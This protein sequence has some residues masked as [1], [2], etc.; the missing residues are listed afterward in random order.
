MAKPGST[1]V[2]QLN[3][4]EGFLEQ[5]DDWAHSP[6]SEQL[7]ASAMQVF[8]HDLSGQQLHSLNVD[9]NA[10]ISDL[11]QALCNT[12]VIPVSAIQRFATDDGAVSLGSATLPLTS[13]GVEDGGILTR[14]KEN[15]HVFAAI[16]REGG[17][18]TVK[19]WNSI[20]FENVR[21]LAHPNARV[22][23]FSLDGS[24]LLTASTAD[25]T[26]KIWNSASDENILTLD[27]PGVHV[28]VFSA[29]GSVV[30][31]ASRDGT[32]KTWNSTSGENI[33]TLPHPRGYSKLYDAVS[34]PDGSLVLTN[35]YHTADGHK[36]LLWNSANG[37]LIF[38]VDDVVGGAVL[39]A[40]SSLV[41]T[42]H[43]SLGMA[44]IRN[45]TRC[46]KFLTLAHLDITLAVFSVD[47][48][49]VLTKGLEDAKVWNATSGENIVTLCDVKHAVFSPD[50]SMVLTTSHETVKSWNSTSGENILTLN[51]PGVSDA[52]FSTDGSL[53]LTVCPSLSPFPQIWNS[54]SGEHILTLAH[55]EG[56]VASSGA[57]SIDDSIVRTDAP[58]GTVRIWNATSGENIC[59]CNGT[60][61]MAGTLA[62]TLL[63][64]KAQALESNCDLSEL[65][66][67]EE[68]LLET[69]SV[70]C[71][72][73]Q[74]DLQNAIL[75]S[76]LKDNL[77]SLTI[78]NDTSSSHASEEASS[79]GGS[80]SGQT[81]V[82][83][84]AGSQP[85]CYVH[86]TL[87]PTM[88]GE[89]KAIQDIK[90]SDVLVSAD[91]SAVE[92]KSNTRHPSMDREMVLLETSSFKI[93]VTLNHRVVVLRGAAPQTI[94][95]GHLR[96]GDPVLSRGGE[97]D[98]IC[99]EHF[100]G[101][102]D[103][104]EM[105]LEPDVAIETF[106]IAKDQ[107]GSLLTKGKRA[108]PRNRGYVRT[109]RACASIEL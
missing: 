5:V 28:A 80:V 52:V 79:L 33:L 101:D 41:L 24:L 91:G 3:V 44:Q 27:H 51:L 50:G 89:H 26:A 20:D 108:I 37:E 61:A 100:F 4:G 1:M 22:A 92:V 96:V 66:M 63:C 85:H 57:F 103:V 11:F 16:S 45:S 55:P 43:Y 47:G 49:L 93:A 95:A 54:T 38:A 98:L 21:T 97:K 64:S 53:V 68:I 73:Q 17:T 82:I 105:V 8:I 30:L 12:D 19:I 15:A 46:E 31:T 77:H 74:D 107:H 70:A 60:V 25:G 6:L 48:S 72:K 39:S 99:V 9:V 2:E 32:V 90:E 7:H 76:K 104:Y 69:D 40:D 94:P 62:I 34:S 86:G 36:A 10:S 18:W 109:S 75:Q 102:M 88:N 35:S 87:F 83:S 42:T 23:V 58:D 84:A 78:V 29:D 81:S 67:L 59:M 106:F 71:F 14:L 56:T 13:C 65:A